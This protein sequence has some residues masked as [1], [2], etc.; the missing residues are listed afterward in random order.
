MNSFAPVLI[1]TLNRFEHF[2][3]C[4]ESLSLCSEA[5]DTDLFIALDY[6]SK[7]THWEGYNKIKNYLNSIS[8]FKTMTVIERE[9]NFG[10]EKNFIEAQKIIFSKFDRMI[11]SEDDNIFS[12]TFL[13]FI[14]CGLDVYKSRKD[15]F[16]ISGYNYPVK[17]PKAYTD[18]VYI[19][20][21]Y[22]AWGVGFWKEK[23][24]LFD[25]E[26]R[27][28][29]LNDLRLFLSD[30][31]NIKKCNAIAKNYVIALKNIIKNDYITGDTL[32][33]YYQIKN[34][35]HSV[36]P[37]INLVKNMGHDGTGIH[38]GYMEND[39]YSRQ[40]ILQENK[41][42]IMP[43]TISDNGSINRVLYN[44]FNPSFFKRLLSWTLR[45]VSLFTKTQ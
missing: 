18:D 42:Y 2:K 24:E 26:N 22:S 14:N 43:Y 39:I 28:K 10:A 33:C 25:Y 9:Y 35:M 32:V 8:L 37:T 30:K 31:Q 40:F 1:V 38:G 29:H 21:G 15:I 36:F 45:K 5:M 44:Y 4:V 17:M 7:D 19:F 41:D 20:K 11:L 34:Q 13:N 3:K 16:S 27:E 6:P 23:W 12:K